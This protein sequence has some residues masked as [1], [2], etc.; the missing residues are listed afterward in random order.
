MI[1]K[2]PL[3]NVLFSY[4]IKQFEGFWKGKIY[5]SSLLILLRKLGGNSNNGYYLLPVENVEIATI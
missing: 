5:G 2:M 4:K 3:I 1:F